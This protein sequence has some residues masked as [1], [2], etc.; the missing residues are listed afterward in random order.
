MSTCYCGGTYR[1]GTCRKDVCYCTGHADPTPDTQAEVTSG[2][3]PNTAHHD[4][5]VEKEELTR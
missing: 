3:Q 4:A 1:C 5:W 2:W